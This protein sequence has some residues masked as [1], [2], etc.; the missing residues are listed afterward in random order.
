[1]DQLFLAI[2]VALIAW[3]L[4]HKDWLDRV[5]SQAYRAF[6]MEQYGTGVA[7]PGDEPLKSGHK[8]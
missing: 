1:M 8:E 5:R 2:S 7:G 4:G 6:L 3:Y